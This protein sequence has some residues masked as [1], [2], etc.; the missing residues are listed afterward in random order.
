MDGDG[1]SARFGVP[2]DQFLRLGFRGLVGTDR[3]GHVRL[4]REVAPILR[5]ARSGGTGKDDAAHIAVPTGLEHALG[6]VAVDLPDGF[7]T[8]APEADSREVEDGVGPVDEV[9][10]RLVVEDVADDYHSTSSRSPDPRSAG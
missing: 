3:L 5:A 1:V 10:Q 4:V 6:P 8:S 9:A 2:I 7:R